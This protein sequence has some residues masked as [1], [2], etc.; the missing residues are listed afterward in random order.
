M[1]CAVVTVGTLNG[2]TAGNI[3]PQS[4]ELKGTT[5]TF[6]AAVQD[7][8]EGRVTTIA[9]KVA[10]AYGAHA[11]VAYRRMYPPT[12][13]HVHETLFAVRVA[14]ALVGEAQ[15]NSELEPIMGSED[16][17]F[18]LEVR[19]GNIMLIGNGDTAGVHDPRYD[20]NDAAIPYGIAYF[21]ALIENGMPL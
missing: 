5:R 3:I 9:H 6:D 21:R 20:F 2:G 1:K 14:R 11:T 19:P 10:A 18:M 12:V 8:I 7:L 15:V 13:N 4:A 16:F 17:A